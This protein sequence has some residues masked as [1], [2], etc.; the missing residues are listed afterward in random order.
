VV[1]LGCALEHRLR[2]K[3]MGTYSPLP[4]FRP[5]ADQPQSSAAECRCSKGALFVAAC[6]AVCVWLGPA[7]A[8]EPVGVGNGGSIACPEK[9]LLEERQE[10]GGRVAWCH[11]EDGTAH[12]PAAAWY[13]DGGLRNETHWVQG[14]K[15]G[16]D[17]SWDQSGSQR[18]E[19]TWVDGR[20]HGISTSWNAAGERERETDYAQGKRDGRVAVWDD[21]GTQI[22]EG[23]FSK[24][25]K[26]G[27]WSFRGSRER[28]AEAAFAV[29]IDD[30]DLTQG[31]LESPLVACAQWS[32]EPAMRRRGYLAVMA[33]LSLRAATEGEQP[34]EFPIAVCIADESRTAVVRLDEACNSAAT[35]FMEAAKRAT[36]ELALFCS[37]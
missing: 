34:D 7:T 37:P 28:S 4:D 14:R 21:A 12:G 8:A 33:L 13:P 15:H 35:D 11:T 2:S 26:H 1:V 31:L 17:L 10:D 30:Q 22:L 36:V 29:M 20:L 23:H 25:L 18:E 32:G 6:L 3:V 9:T 19:S 27:I 5:S 24:G 16:R